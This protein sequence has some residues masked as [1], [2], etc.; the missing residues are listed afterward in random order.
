[1]KQDTILVKQ[2]EK[3]KKVKE[4]YVTEKKETVIA[5]IALN[6]TININYDKAKKTIKL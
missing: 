1:M 3:L 5:K 4:I 6:E 2:K